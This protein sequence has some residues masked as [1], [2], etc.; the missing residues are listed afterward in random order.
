MFEK[1]RISFLMKLLAKPFSRD[2]AH[3]AAIEERGRPSVLLLPEVKPFVTVVPDAAVD[4]D[5]TQ[6]RDDLDDERESHCEL[7]RDQTEPMLA[8]TLFISS[9]SKISKIVKCSTSDSS[10]SAGLIRN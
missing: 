6:P 3:D 1:Y 7:A 5:A 2:R 8:L 4:G 10:I 9:S